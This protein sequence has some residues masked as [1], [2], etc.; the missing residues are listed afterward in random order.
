[1]P[2]TPSARTAPPLTSGMSC[3]TAYALT[4]WRVAGLSVQSRMRSKE[5][6]RREG[7]AEPVV[8][9]GGWKRDGVKAS[10]WAWM[11]MSEL[12]LQGRSSQH[13]HLLSFD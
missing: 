13:E 4:N 8:D 6:E 3:A 12:S 10:S 7:G 11:T 9:E 5:P 1:M 2:T